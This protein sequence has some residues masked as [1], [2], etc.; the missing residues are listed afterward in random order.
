M[1]DLVAQGLAEG[2]AAETQLVETPIASGYGVDLH[3]TT[4]IREDLA[5][6][7]PDSDEAIGEAIFRRWT[8]NRGENP[9]DLEYGRNVT[10][11]LNRGMTFAD[12]A[13]EAGL[14][15]AEAEKD[16]RV[17][18]CVVTLTQSNGGRDVRVA[19]TVTPKDPNREP[20]RF[21]VAVSDGKA[22]LELTG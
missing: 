18:T 12:L 20:F 3:C 16:E 9:D 22:L 6:V 17:D 2:L 4:D 15:R 14:L 5:E 1:N 13:A 11:L 8:C 10:S 19:A 7:D 21:V